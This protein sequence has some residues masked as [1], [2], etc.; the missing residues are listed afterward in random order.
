MML[1][2]LKLKSYREYIS[3][4]TCLVFGP[5]PPL[6]N[7]KTKCVSVDRQAFTFLTIAAIVTMTSTV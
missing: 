2:D 7:V 5:L 6:K 3:S 4:L 1:T